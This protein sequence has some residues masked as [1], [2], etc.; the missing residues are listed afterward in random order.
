MND[1]VEMVMQYCDNEKESL[2]KPRFG[3]Y[4]RGLYA[5][6]DRLNYDVIWRQENELNRKD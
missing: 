6:L 5:R 4:D 2:P 3:F 1:R